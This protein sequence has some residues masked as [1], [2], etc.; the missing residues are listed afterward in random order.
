MR[1]VAG[2]EVGI[3]EERI[4]ENQGQLVVG[5]DFMMGTRDAADGTRHTK[6][7]TEEEFHTHEVLTIILRTVIL[8]NKNAT[9]ENEAATA[10]KS[11]KRNSTG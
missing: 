10:N 2:P 9:A 6:E 8:H 11:A 3:G 4:V 1:E 5:D 7:E